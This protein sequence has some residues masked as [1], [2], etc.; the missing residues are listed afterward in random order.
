MSL[1][2]L[3]MAQTE[4]LDVIG[5]RVSAHSDLLIT[6]TC[7]HMATARQQHLLYQDEQHYE[8]TTRSVCNITMSKTID[9]CPN[10]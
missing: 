1:D 4:C 2:S 10:R 3:C 7:D 8:P 5:V 6:I 9:R